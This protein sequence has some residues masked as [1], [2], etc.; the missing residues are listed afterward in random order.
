M[1]WIYDL[2]NDPGEIV[3]RSTDPLCKTELARL[4]HRMVDWM[5]RTGDRLLNPFTRPSLLEGR[6]G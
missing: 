4:R 5:D 3:N 6:S 2:E 1:H